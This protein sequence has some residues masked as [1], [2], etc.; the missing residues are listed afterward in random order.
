MPSAMFFLVGAFIAGSNAW[1]A[2]RSVKNRDER[3]PGQ[4]PSIIPLA[5]GL[6]MVVGMLT[7]P[8]TSL[9]TFAWV[10]LFL[11]YGCLPTLGRAAAVALFGRPQPEKLV[12][13]RVDAAAPAT[14]SA[15]P[16]EAAQ[17]TPAN[18]HFDGDGAAT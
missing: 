5:G 1:G 16:P 17:V 13:V 9:H 2:L 15:A 4:G 3:Q 7:A 14:P 18:D 6:M 11:D 12:P 10:P 8:L